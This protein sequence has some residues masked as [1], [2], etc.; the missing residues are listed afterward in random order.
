M[1]KQIEALIRDNFPP[2][3]VLQL[4]VFKK[5]FFGDPEIKLLPRLL[6]GDKSNGVDVGAYRGLFSYHLAKYCTNV[7]TYEA[8]PFLSDWLKKAVPSNVILKNIG[9]SS[10]KKNMT[11]SIPIIKGK[12][13]ASRGSFEFTQI[14]ENVGKSRK[15]DVEVERLDDQ[16]LKD[17]SFI[18]IDVE[19]HEYAVLDGAKNLIEREKPILL[20]EIEQRHC[21]NPIEQTF[22]LLNELNLEAFFLTK[23]K[24][25]S[26]IKNFNKAVHQ[27]TINNEIADHDNYVNNFIFIP[28]ERISSYG[29]LILEH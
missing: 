24:K 16:D 8:N 18:K 1:I 23:D 20:V 5:R 27:E 12:E 4:I 19:G 7:Y 22:E 15:M 17:I 2:K 26:H 10:E 9:M 11:F 6:N 25:L 21:S 14:E 3:L 29:E 28:K 13:R